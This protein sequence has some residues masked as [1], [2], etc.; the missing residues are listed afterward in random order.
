MWKWKKKTRRRNG[1]AH[2]HTRTRRRARKC[3][4]K[5]TFRLLLFGKWCAVLRELCGQLREAAS[6]A[7][8]TTTTQYYTAREELPRI[9]NFFFPCADRSGSYGG[10]RSVCARFFFCCGFAHKRLHAWV[11]SHF[12]YNYAF[13]LDFFIEET[14][15]AKKNESSKQQSIS[16][17]Q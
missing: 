17:T 1:L 3:G 6:A 8:G 12:V 4:I 11:T 5:F 16:R 9:T 15:E 10:K 7:I 14:T 2:A 13:F